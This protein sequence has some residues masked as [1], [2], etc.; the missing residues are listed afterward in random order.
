MPDGLNVLVVEGVVGLIEIDPKPHPLGHRFPVADIAHHRFAAAAGELCYAD[1]LFNF[2]FV[3]DPEFFLNLVFDRQAVGIPSGFAR[4]ME[5]LHGFVTGIDILETARQDVVNAGFA[6]GRRRP[7]IEGKER[8]TRALL[9]AF[10]KHCLLP[11]EF[12]DVLLEGRAVVACVDFA[13]THSGSRVLVPSP[14]LVSLRGDSSCPG[15]RSSRA[16]PPG[17]AGRAPGLGTRFVCR[18]CIE[19]QSAESTAGCSRD[20]PGFGQRLRGDFH[21]DPARGFQPPPVSGCAGMPD[22]SS[23]STPLRPQAAI[24]FL[25]TG[26]KSTRAT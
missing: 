8:P 18:T 4:H 9:Q 15:E 20:M 25:Q 19:G 22:Y 6:V 5:P 7:L 13:E 24:A 17:F 26:A 16:V 11:P 3:E 2:F 21:W 12:K 1:G 14:G 23:P 10:F